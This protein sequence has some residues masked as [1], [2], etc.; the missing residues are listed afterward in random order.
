ML[1]AEVIITPAVAIIFEKFLRKKDLLAE[2][3]TFKIRTN[4]EPLRINK[5]II[6]VAFCVKKNLASAHSLSLLFFGFFFFLA[7][8]DKLS[9]IETIAHTSILASTWQF[10]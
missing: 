4:P 5:I 10:A 9:Q 2:M 7:M 1:D 6:E 3:K 8:T